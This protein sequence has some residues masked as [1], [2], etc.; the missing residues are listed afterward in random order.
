MAIK[1]IFSFIK[2]LHN[3]ALKIKVLSCEKASTTGCYAGNFAIN[4]DTGSY[5]LSI[6]LFEYTDGPYLEYP[7][8]EVYNLFSCTYAYCAMF[9]ISCFFFFSCR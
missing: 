1:T 6:Q 9:L 8:L 7:N 5:I 3:I 2:I 4:I